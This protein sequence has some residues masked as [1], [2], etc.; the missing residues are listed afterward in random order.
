MPVQFV[1]V[2]KHD[3]VQLQRHFSLSLLDHC[4][5]ELENPSAA[6]TDQVV[7]MFLFDFVAGHP[8]VKTTF[9]GE[10]GLDEKFQ[11]AIDR[12]VADP[13]VVLANQLIEILTGQVPA[14]FEKRFE[15]DLALFRLLEAV[16]LKVLRKRF[17][18]ELVRHCPK[19]SRPS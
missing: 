4:R 12:R 14:G 17:L 8:I 1:A 5:F 7:V 10:F 13:G 2:A 9:L 3:E 16:G 6:K 15:D 18:L 19:F 11:G